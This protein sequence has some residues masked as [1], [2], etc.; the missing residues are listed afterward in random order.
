MDR[1]PGDG[2]EV[3]DVGNVGEQVVV[4]PIGEELIFLPVAAVFEGEDRNGFVQ[5]FDLKGR[6]AGG[7]AIRTSSGPGGAGERM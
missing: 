4:D 2:L 1:G 3:A 7:E 6:G 5:V